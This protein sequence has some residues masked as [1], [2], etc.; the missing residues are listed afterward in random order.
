MTKIIELTIRY[1]NISW[2]FSCGESDYQGHPT[3]QHTKY[4]HYHLQML[5]DHRQL[6]NFNDFH[7]PLHDK[8]IWSIELKRKIPKS[9][10][11]VAY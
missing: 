3:S 4:P 10:S 9:E 6:I 1:Q 2:S 11:L 7:L 8:D 5:V